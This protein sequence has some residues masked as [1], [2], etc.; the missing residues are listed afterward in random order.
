M[1]PKTQCNPAIQHAC[2]LLTLGGIC[3]G[4][5]ANALAEDKQAKT[6]HP[7]AV[8]YTNPPIA[9]F[10]SQMTDGLL[11]G[12]K[13]EKPVW[14]LHD[15]LQLPAWLALTLEQRSRFE[16]LAGSFRANSKG[17]D[18]Q[19]ALQTSLW[20]EAKHRQFRVGAEFLDARGLG[21]DSGSAINNTQVD[22]ADF[23]QAYAAWADKNLFYSGVGAELIVGRQTLNLGSRRLVGRTVY[24]NTNNSF[25]GGRLH[26]TNYSKWQLNTFI[27]MPVLRLPTSTANLLN[28]THQFDEEDTHTLF[29]GG[30]LEVTDIL[31]GMDA[32]F[33]VYHLN[34]GDSPNNLTRN[35]RYVTPGVRLL[36]KPSKAQFDFQWETI[37]QIGTVHAS[38]AATDNVEQQHAAWFEHID[39]GYTL[40]IPWAPRLSLE[41][42]YASGDQDPNDGKEQR[43][44]TLFGV[45]DFEYGPAGIYNGLAR[46]NVNSPGYR[47]KFNPRPNLEV[48]FAQR[49][50]WLAEAKD[51]WG[52]SG[53]Q[54]K[55]GRSGDAVGQQ[56]ELKARY[57]FNSS[58]NVETGWTHLAKGEFA[59]HA[60]GAPKGVDTEY[61]FVQTLLRF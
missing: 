40:D 17:G 43:F 48:S 59:K 61:F 8:T 19:I 42:D 58:L 18:Q 22:T 35:R 23:V 41:Y 4:S 15:A 51:S 21:A 56:L 12:G 26:I 20:L 38:T 39:V 54:D 11:G 9:A 2:N 50:I 31:W 5:V 13:Y 47:L 60:P 30:L 32:D 1:Q 37:G 14:N 49:A 45:A 16:T 57:F 33:F 3:F 25:T 24:R 27:S 55:S 6:T 7:P 46:S 10:S 53:L 29:S 28:D 52:S 34:E 44:D 36:S